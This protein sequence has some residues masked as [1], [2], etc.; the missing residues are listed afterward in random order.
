MSPHTNQPSHRPGHK[1]EC[2]REQKALA[3][4]ALAAGGGCGETAAV[5]AGFDGNPTVEASAESNSEN[6]APCDHCA[7][8][9]PEAELLVCMG[10]LQG[11]YC[12][13]AC[14]HSAWFVR[15]GQFWNLNIDETQKPPI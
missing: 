12:S 4:A 7:G 5:P 10:C 14:Q 15:L 8:L 1:K 3:A 13:V 11:R 2:K 9:T 6:G